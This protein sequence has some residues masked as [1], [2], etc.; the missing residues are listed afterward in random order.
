M[1]FGMGVPS[2]TTYKMH[3]KLVGACFQCKPP[4][5]DIYYNMLYYVMLYIISNYI[6]RLGRLIGSD[7]SIVAAKGDLM[8]SRWP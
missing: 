2:Q 5:G 6:L 8:A 1:R 4:L 7:S 3:I